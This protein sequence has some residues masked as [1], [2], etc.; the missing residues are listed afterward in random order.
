[1]DASIDRG[2][3]EEKLQQ[4]AT[5]IPPGDPLSVKT[6]GAHAVTDSRKGTDTNVVLEYQFPNKWLLVGMTVHSVDGRSTIAG[7]FLKPEE[8][9]LEEAN[10]FKLLGK[11]PLQYAILAAAIASLAWMI[12]ALVACIRTPMEKRKW[13]WIILVLA[14]IAQVGVNWTTGETFYR[15]FYVSV[16]TATADKAL[17]GPWTIVVSIP[18]GAILF[19]ILRDGLRRRETPVAAH[20]DSDDGRNSVL[21]P[22][23]A[24]G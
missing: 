8:Q 23:P 7:F 13:L 18:V 1:M 3:L 16:P 20:V 10:R 24:Q 17:F 14:G 4:M 12:Y 21:H 9:S 22:P 19:L 11:Q 5:M 15:I 6:V 2:T